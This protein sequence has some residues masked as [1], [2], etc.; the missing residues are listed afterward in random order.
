MNVDRLDYF[1]GLAM[2][3]FLIPT[4]NLQSISTMGR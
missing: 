4:M 3:Q 2:Q 1:A